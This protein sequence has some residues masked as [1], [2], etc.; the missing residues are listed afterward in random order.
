MLTLKNMLCI[1]AFLCVTALE[2]QL[3][4]P[5]IRTDSTFNIYHDIRVED[6]YQWLENT[7]SLEVLE[8]IENQN[9]FTTK[10]LKKN[11]VRD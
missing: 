10:Y 9:K 3:K 6:R 4:Y 1:V 11:S 5:E 8:W 2:A 7:T